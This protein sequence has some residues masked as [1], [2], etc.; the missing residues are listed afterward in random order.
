MLLYI[1]GI[2]KLEKGT[3]KYDAATNLIGVGIDFDSCSAG[4]A[5][6]IMK[7][8]DVP[9]KNPKY[10]VPK[11]NWAKS[12]RLDNQGDIVQKNNNVK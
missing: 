10:N 6:T 12:M 11:T 9:K 3:D 1:S 7:L 4:P 5:E 8:Q 2:T